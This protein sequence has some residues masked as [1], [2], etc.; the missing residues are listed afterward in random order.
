MSKSILSDC[1]ARAA[2]IAVYNNNRDYNS[3]SKK[4]Y[5]ATWNSEHL[6]SLISTSDAEAAC[7]LREAVRH[8]V[9]KVLAN[10]NHTDTENQLM[11]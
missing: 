5:F 9:E 2:L 8:A 3:T 7:E 10:Y 6:Y 1:I 4:Y 11:P